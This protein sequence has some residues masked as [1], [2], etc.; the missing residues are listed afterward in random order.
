MGTTFYRSFVVDNCHVN[1]NSY[2]ALS[3]NKPSCF[4]V[5]IDDIVPDD[6]FTSLSLWKL[7]DFVPGSYGGFGYF[8]GDGAVFDLYYK[9]KES[10]HSQRD[11]TYCVYP[12][13]W[14][15]FDAV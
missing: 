3:D 7:L 8:I 15:I 12:G 4:S 10:S 14:S 5:F 2:I 11:T 13:T 6:Y 9:N 1:A